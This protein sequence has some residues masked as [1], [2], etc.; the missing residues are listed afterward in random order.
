MEFL[1][2]LAASTAP[3]YLTGPVVRALVIGHTVVLAMA[4]P[5][6]VLAARGYRGTPWGRALKPLPVVTA[7]LM[8]SSAANFVLEDPQRAGYAGALLWGV[9]GLGIG[10]SVLQ[11][12]VLLTGRRE[13]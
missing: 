7:A 4:F 6:A 13:L 11:T 12:F 5:F 10:W 8:L 2:S 3:E 1:A 9:A